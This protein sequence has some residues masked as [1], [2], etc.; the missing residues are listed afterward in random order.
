MNN[1]KVEITNGITVKL[2]SMSRGLVE[3]QNVQL[4]KIDSKE[5]NLVIMKDY[6]PIIG[7]IEGKVEIDLIDDTIKI[8]NIVGYYMHKHN[9]FNLFIKEE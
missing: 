4:I 9:Q 3:Y 1:K 5:Y 2:L 6:M 8:Q 7:E